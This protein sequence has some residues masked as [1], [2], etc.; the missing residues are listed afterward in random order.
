MR[1]HFDR[2][3]SLLMNRTTFEAHR[4]LWGVEDKPARAELQ[5]LTDEER[6]LYQDL[7][8]NRF[9]PNRRLE[10]EHVGF[11]SLIAQLDALGVE[12]LSRNGPRLL[13]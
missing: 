9:G 11:H 6:A 13:D 10:Q 5:R 12:R 3:R 2:T 7:Q 4:V 1:A 8:Q